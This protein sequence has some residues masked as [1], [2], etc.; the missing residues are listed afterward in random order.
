MN[1]IF[2]QNESVCFIKKYCKDKLH[3]REYSGFQKTYYLCLSQQTSQDF[4]LCQFMKEQKIKNI[5]VKEL[6]LDINFVGGQLIIKYISTPL[7]TVN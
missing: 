6:E 1:Y 2:N 3:I 5:D 7:Y 4:E